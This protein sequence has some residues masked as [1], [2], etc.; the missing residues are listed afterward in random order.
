MEKLRLNRTKLMQK[1]YSTILDF[2]KHGYTSHV[3]WDW[4]CDTSKFMNWLIG[5]ENAEEPF[6]IFIRR[7]GCE[8]GT[9]EYVSERCAEFGGLVLM[10]KI[11]KE[12]HID[13]SYNITLDL[14]K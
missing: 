10:I 8:A 9:L 4:A 11:E 6:Y 2:D 12:S 3:L 5:Y 14:N 1:V 7:T 13:E